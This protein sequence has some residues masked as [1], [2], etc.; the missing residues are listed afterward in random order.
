MLSIEIL[1]KS[2]TLLTD[3]YISKASVTRDQMLERP[4]VKMDHL[5]SVYRET[6]NSAL[7]KNL[8]VKAL[9]KTALEFKTLAMFTISVL[10]KI[11]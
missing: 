11:E 1:F 8:V 9:G 4:T 7:Q 10:F 6:S 3:I 2:I 5:S